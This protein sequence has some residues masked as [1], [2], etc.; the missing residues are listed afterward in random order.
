MH[1]RCCR[2]VSSWVHY[3]TSCTH[4]LVLLK[5]GEIIARTMS[6]WL[7]IINKSLSLHL[8]GCL[9]YL[10]QWCAVK[11]ISK[12]HQP[13]YLYILEYIYELF[14]N[15]CT[16]QNALWS[17]LQHTQWKWLP[18]CLTTWV[19]KSVSG[20]GLVFTCLSTLFPQPEGLQKDRLLH[21]DSSKLFQASAIFAENCWKR[22]M[23]H[24]LQTMQANPVVPAKTLLNH[25][26]PHWRFKVL[27]ALATTT[28]FLINMLLPYS[29]RGNEV[30]G[31]FQ[32]AGIYQV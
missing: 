6:R 26:L 8:V 21:L 14:A 12:W 20:Y 24:N 17:N 22:Q 11:Q 31:F 18:S 10:F 27:M 9:Y 13:S 23:T 29:W 3:T 4:I 7:R 15:P 28:R 2:P 32:N 5:L 1:P 19:G 16:L 30:C 25:S